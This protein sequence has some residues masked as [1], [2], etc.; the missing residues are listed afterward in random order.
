MLKINN[1]FVSKLRCAAPRGGFLGSLG[2]LNITL[3]Q[4]VLGRFSLHAK[5]LR[6]MP[7]LAVSRISL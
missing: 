4:A 2:S 6:A 1:R 7:I 5:T 3:A